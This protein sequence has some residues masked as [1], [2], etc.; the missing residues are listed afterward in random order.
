MDPYTVGLPLGKV[1]LLVTIG[2]LVILGLI[3]L[4]RKVAN[5]KD[6]RHPYNKDVH[7]VARSMDGD[8]KQETLWY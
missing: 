3:A 6:T 7:G 4:I 5:L 8:A 2:G 1:E